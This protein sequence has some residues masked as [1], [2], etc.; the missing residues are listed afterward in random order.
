VKEGGSLTEIQIVM[1]G[2]SEG[3]LDTIPAFYKREG[4]KFKGLESHKKQ[5]LKRRRSPARKERCTRIKKEAGAF[6]QRRWLGE[7]V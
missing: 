5:C 3:H 2:D 1:K 7:D 4:L 6:V